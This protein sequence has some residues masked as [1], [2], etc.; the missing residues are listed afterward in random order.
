MSK[1]HPAP[2]HRQNQFSQ[3]ELLDCAH[4]RLFGASNARLPAPP[5]LMMDRIC[6]ITEDGG[7]YQRGHI[8]AELDVR[9]DLWFFHL[10]F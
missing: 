8:H 9:P 4:G 1:S 5:M 3:A 6:S 2:E 10:P 7:R